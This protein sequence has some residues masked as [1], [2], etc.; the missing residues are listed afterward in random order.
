MAGVKGRSGPPGNLNGATSGIEVWL[1]RRMLPVHKRHIGAFIQT[2]RAGLLACKG[3]DA[4]ATEVETGLID[5]AARAYGACLLILEEA[6]NKGLVRDV[7]GTWDL[8]PGFARIT[9]FLAAERLAL[10]ALGLERRARDVPSARDLLTG[11]VADVDE[12]SDGH[13]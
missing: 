6:A 7:G 10:V 8:T 1:K 3:G 2:Y 12:E 11:R 13:S 9:Q 4:G 5:N